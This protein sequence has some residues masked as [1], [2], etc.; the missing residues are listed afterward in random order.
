[1]TLTPSDNIVPT[2]LYYV[3]VVPIAANGDSGEMSGPDACFRFQPS[4]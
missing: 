3:T 2:Q 4:A 1:M